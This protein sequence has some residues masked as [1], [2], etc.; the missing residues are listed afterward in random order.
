LFWGLQHLALPW[1]ADGQYLAWRG[2]SATAAVAGFTL[3]FAWR[4]KLVP[5]I[6]V[7]YLADLATALMLALPVLSR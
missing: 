3:V 2:L 1:L 5:L 4:R 7:H 6:G